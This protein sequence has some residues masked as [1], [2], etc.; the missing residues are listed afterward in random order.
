MNENEAYRNMTDPNLQE[1]THVYEF[2]RNWQTGLGALIGSLLGF[3][4][5]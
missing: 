1:A 5:F 2:L 3:L 4:V